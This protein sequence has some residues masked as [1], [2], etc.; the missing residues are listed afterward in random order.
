MIILKFRRLIIDKNIKPFEIFEYNKN[1]Y[2]VLLDQD[3]YWYDWV[4]EQKT[5]SCHYGDGHCYNDAFHDYLEQENI[6]LNKSLDYD[7]ENGMFCVYCKS[8][9][10]AKLVATELSMLYNNE[11]KMLELIKNTKEKYQYEFDIDVKI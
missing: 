11:N 6:S 10:D 1:L 5:T 9:E 7:S 2:A 8:L 4:L 3:Y